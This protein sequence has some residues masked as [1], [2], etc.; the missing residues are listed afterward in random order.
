MSRDGENCYLTGNR[1][2][3]QIALWNKVR[4]DHGPCFS[5]KN[6]HVTGFARNLT[7]SFAESNPDCALAN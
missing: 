5:G 2:E 1:L 4:R 3:I 6:E 7:Q